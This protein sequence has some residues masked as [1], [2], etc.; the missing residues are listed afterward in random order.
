LY[1][2]GEIVK[3]SNCYGKYYEGFFKNEKYPAIFVLI[4]KN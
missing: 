3:W 4:V 2:A 1:T